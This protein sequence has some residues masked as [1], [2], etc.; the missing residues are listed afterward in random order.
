MSAIFLR[1]VV[2]LVHR[3]DDVRDGLRAAARDDAGRAGEVVGLHRGVG[4]L[5]HVAGELGH[6]AGRVLQAAGG[7]LGALAQVLVADG[8]FLAGGA[9]RFGGAADV[10]DQLAQL[11][12]HAGE[13]LQ[14]LAEFVVT[15]GMH[16]RRQVALGDAACEVHRAL[17]RGL[18]AADQAPAD[19]RA[20]GD[21]RAR[22]GEQDDHQGLFGDLRAR[23]G[24]GAFGGDRL[25]QRLQLGAPL[26]FQRQDAVGERQRRLDVVAVGALLRGFLDHR[27]RGRGQRGDVLD[28]AAFVVVGARPGDQRLQRLFV[29]QVAALGGLEVVD[30]GRDRLHLGH[31]RD[32][33]HLDGHLVHR[34]AQVADGVGHRVVDL[35]HAFDLGGDHLGLPAADGGAEQRQGHEGA[36]TEGES[37]GDGQVLARGELG[38]GKTLRVFPYI[39]RHVENLSLGLHSRRPRTHRAPRRARCRVRKRRIGRRSHFLRPSNCSNQISRQ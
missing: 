14:E 12:L 15:V 22:E 32:A 19:Q 16:L 5:A 23:G 6:R 18:D 7:L 3:R 28:R 1:A 30:L 4:A 31:E 26:L 29:G 25:L 38:H 10:S 20:D 21:G 39:G 2:D 35:D 34:V 36:E 24:A 8:H 33:A 37:L 9:D 17:Q 13:R 27:D 11:G